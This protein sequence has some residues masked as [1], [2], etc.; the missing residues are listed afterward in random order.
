MKRILL[1]LLL[2]VSISVLISAQEVAP[3]ELNDDQAI[4][5]DKSVSKML[6]NKT[7]KSYKQYTVRGEESQEY[8]SGFLTFA[9]KNDHTFQAIGAGNSNNSGTWE[10]RKKELLH[11]KIADDHVAGKEK[12]MGGSY[13]IYEITADELVLVK[14]LTSDL[15]AKIIYYCKTSERRDLTVKDEKYVT[16]PVIDTKITIPPSIKIKK[17][18]DM[19]LEEL[20][21]EL[22][23]EFFI[24]V[25]ESPKKMDKLNRE[26]LIELLQKV[27][28]GTY[29]E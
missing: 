24:R 4:V 23:S 7:W 10:V 20:K 6:V 16:T 25:L 12:V 8:G 3:F 19:T 27:K 28:N 18:E 2:F 5:I 1:L 9:L 26:A 15:E 29:Q 21:S 11:L 13:V 22:Q 17:L 14:N